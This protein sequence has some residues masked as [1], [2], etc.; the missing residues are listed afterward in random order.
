MSGD[1]PWPRLSPVQHHDGSL[2]C[3]WHCHVDYP[4]VWMSL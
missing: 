1:T 4:G 2:S 3:Q